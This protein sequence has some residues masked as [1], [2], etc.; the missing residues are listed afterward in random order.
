MG[1][2][3][4]RKIKISFTVRT[5]AGFKQCTKE[6]ERNMFL[7]VESTKK[8]ALYAGKAL[9]LKQPA[10]TVLMNAGKRQK[11]KEILREDISQKKQKDTKKYAKFA[12]KALLL[13]Q[14]ANFALTN[15]G[16]N[17]NLTGIRH[18]E[19]DF[20]KIFTKMMI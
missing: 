10:N 13:T 1:R 7:K 19:K 3:L 20:V 8:Y 16:K 17:P 14:T 18:T 4:N 11:K 5:I 15:V 12:E 6:T 2:N 9:F